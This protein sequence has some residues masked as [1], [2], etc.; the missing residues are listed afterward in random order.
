MVDFDV[1]DEPYPPQDKEVNIVFKRCQFLYLIY[2]A[3]DPDCIEPTDFEILAEAKLKIEETEQYLLVTFSKEGKGWEIAGVGLYLTDN[4]IW[5]YYFNGD[6]E[7]ERYKE[8]IEKMDEDAWSNY[9]PQAN[10]LYEM[11]REKLREIGVLK[12][13]QIMGMFG[14]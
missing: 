13:G 10:E 11:I 3:D 1:F 6:Y 9:M 7:D 5:P 12:E 2:D 8:T 4:S 14:L